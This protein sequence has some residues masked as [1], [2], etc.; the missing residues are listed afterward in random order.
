M[1]GSCSS[2]PLTCAVCACSI[3]GIGTF[4]IVCG[5]GG[6]SKH[7]SAWFDQHSECPAGCGCP[8]SEIE[9]PPIEMDNNSKRTLPEPAVLDAIFEDSHDTK[10]MADDD[11]TS[12]DSDGSSSYVSSS[13]DSFGF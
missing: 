8:C 9:A 13:E 10:V 3:R 12:D 4:C 1:C 11:Y 2:F 7:L 6:H 5:H